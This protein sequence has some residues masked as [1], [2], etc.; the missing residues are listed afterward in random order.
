MAHIWLQA[1]H[2]TVFP[3]HCSCAVGEVIPAW[4]EGWERAWIREDRAASTERYYDI[5]C[6][7]VSTGLLR[8]AL[9]TLCAKRACTVDHVAW[10]DYRR[11]WAVIQ[12]AVRLLPR[13]AIAATVLATESYRATAKI[14]HLTAE[15]ALLTRFHTVTVRY[16]IHA[17]IQNWWNARPRRFAASSLRLFHAEA[18]LAA[19]QLHFAGIVQAIVAEPTAEVLDVAHRDDGRPRALALRLH[20]GRGSTPHNVVGRTC[21]H[22]WRSNVGS[23]A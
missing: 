18:V 19:N 8:G 11:I 23:L 22:D 14:G 4:I 9:P 13:K 15:I 7:V 12:Q 17:W 1:S 2:L 21:D 6:P 10:R 5:T 3:R 16:I 20:K